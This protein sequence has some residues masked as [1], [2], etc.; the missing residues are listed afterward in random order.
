[1]FCAHC[2]ATNPDNAQVCA[3]CGQ[4]VL[5]G[6]PYRSATASATPDVPYGKVPNYL[7]QSILATLCCCLP[8]GI[9][10]I[11]YA[12]Q[13]DGKL[14]A[15]NYSGAVEA[16]NSAKMWCWIS[17]GIGLPIFLVWFALS[18]FGFIAQVRENIH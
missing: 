7:V 3:A 4:S 6:N 8:F 16:S 11:V 5:A 2:G 17:F 15:R 18:L 10:A 9:V 1:M 13:V 14:A 12:A